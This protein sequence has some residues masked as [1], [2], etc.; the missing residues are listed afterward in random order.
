[1]AEPNEPQNTA[2]WLHEFAVA[3]KGL[4]PSALPL[5]E[6]VGATLMLRR[7]AGL[8]PRGKAVERVERRLTLV[9]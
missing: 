5:H 2:D 8:S 7:L 9:R 6:L 1:M 4:D 3:A